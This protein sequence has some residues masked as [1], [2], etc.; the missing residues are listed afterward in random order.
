MF[1]SGFVPSLLDGTEEIFNEPKNIGLPKQFS[2]LKYLPKVLN[3]GSNPICVPC[4]ISAFLNWDLNLK[5]GNKVDNKINVFDIFENANGGNDGMSFK[6]AL[7]YLVDKGTDSKQ[8][9]IKIARYAKVNSFMALKY[10]IF[11]NGPCVGGLPVYDSLRDKFWEGKTKPTE[12]Y[13]AVSIIGYDENGFIIRNSWG[14]S[15]GEDGYEYIKNEDCSKFTE[16]W[17]MIR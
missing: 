10:A 6:D 2:Y 3:Q 9:K 7:E 12:G 5:D 15:Y 14:E 17:T 1:N 11:V 8:G 13:H 4:S 16:I